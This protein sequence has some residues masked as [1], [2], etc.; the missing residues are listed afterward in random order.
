VNG[1]LLTRID[2]RLLHGQVALGWRDALDPAGFLIID[3]GIAGDPLAVT[4]FEAALPDGMRLD[5]LDTSEFLSFLQGG[6]KFSGSPERTVL[7]LRNLSILG[8]LVD[9]GFRPREV[10][11]GGI[12]HHGDARRYLDYIYLTDED[13]RLARR[14]IEA[15]I[16]LYAQDLPTAHRRPIAE[17]FATGG[18]P[19]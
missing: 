7:L 8:R 12:H 5:V 13:C 1:F 11:I 4:L 15:G 18:K 3:D 10:N 16:V 19:V 9:V 2:D 6:P 14:L 17:L